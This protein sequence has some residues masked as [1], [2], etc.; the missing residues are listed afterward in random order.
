MPSWTL[1]ELMSEATTRIGRRADLAQSTVS[2]YVNQAHLDVAERTD[3][4]ESEQTAISS[5]VSRENR[6]SVPSDAREIISVSNRSSGQTLRPMRIEEF[7][8]TDT[9]DRG[10]PTEFA[11]WQN[12]LFLHPTSDSTYTFRIRYRSQ[13]TDMTSTSDVPSV[14]TSFRFPILLKAEQYLLEYI[15][16]DIGAAAKRN[17]YLDQIRSLDDETARRQRANRNEFALKT[18]S[19]EPD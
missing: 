19:Y 7:D 6:I 8:S 2:R 1:G 18:Y 9:S 16:D 17:A 14:D 15:G 13:A 12:D 10:T 3:Q 4:A 5:T 11:F